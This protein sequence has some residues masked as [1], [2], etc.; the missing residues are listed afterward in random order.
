MGGLA[1]PALIGTWG[2]LFVASIVITLFGPPL[3]VPNPRCAPKHYKAPE[4]LIG[5]IRC[6]DMNDKDDRA[7]ADRLLREDEVFLAR[8]EAARKARAAK[9]GPVL[10]FFK[11]VL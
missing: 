1:K 10:A 4:E 5:T 9:E 7:I 2:G 8:E 6:L 3:P 11:G